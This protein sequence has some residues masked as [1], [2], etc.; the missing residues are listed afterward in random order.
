MMDTAAFR[1]LVHIAGRRE[2][3]MRNGFSLPPHLR[4]GI[5]KDVASRSHSQGTVHRYIDARVRA[6][7]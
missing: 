2:A 4:L 5:L 1:F 3:D 7:V 6:C